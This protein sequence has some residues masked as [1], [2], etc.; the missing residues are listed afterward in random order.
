M[1]YYTPQNPLFSGAVAY[2]VY[3]IKSLLNLP[4]FLSSNSRKVTSPFLSIV[5]FLIPP[6]SISVFSQTLW[7]FLLFLQSPSPEF[8]MQLFANLH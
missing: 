7:A 4:T 2:R 8:G 5:F 6:P 3:G 1:I